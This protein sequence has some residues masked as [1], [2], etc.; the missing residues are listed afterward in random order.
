MYI[1]A[2]HSFR[3]HN[4]FCSTSHGARTQYGVYNHRS[5]DSV[6]GL[7]LCPSLQCSVQGLRCSLSTWSQY[8][9]CE[10]QT[11]PSMTGLRA[12]GLEMHQAGVRLRIPSGGTRGRQGLTETLRLQWYSAL[13]TLTCSFCLGIAMH[14]NHILWAISAIYCMDP[15]RS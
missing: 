3:V 14:Q 12:T 9:T 10:T 5:E 7:L 13:P 11:L 15:E 6:L 8:R 2:S 1:L 4:C